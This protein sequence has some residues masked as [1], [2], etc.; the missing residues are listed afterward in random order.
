MINN[1]FTVSEDQFRQGD[2]PSI[3]EEIQKDERIIINIAES[4][5]FTSNEFPQL[6][7]EIWRKVCFHIPPRK[8]DIPYAKGGVQS[9][10]ENMHFSKQLTKIGKNEEKEWASEQLVSLKKYRCNT[11]KEAIQYAISHDLTGVNLIEFPDLEE[12]DIE[13]LFKKCPN[14][15]QLMI[16]SDKIRNL[17]IQASN[18]IRLDCKGC[19]NLQNLP[20]LPIVRVL[21]C[22]GCSNLQSLPELPNMQELNCNWCTNLHSLPELSNVQELNCSWCANLLSLPELPNVQK[23]N[24]KCLKLHSLPEL[25]NVQELNCSWCAN[26][27]SLPGLPNVQKLNCS[28]CSSLQS[29]PELPNVQK[30]DCIRCYNLLSLPE[31]PNVQELYCGWCSNLQSLPELPNVQ[32]LDFSRCSNLQN[33]PKLS[34]GARIFR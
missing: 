14:L 6:P 5:F 8:F 13:E 26:L 27:L 25:P 24:C 9:G 18:L 22:S 16:K 1:Q 29:L 11:A 28:W 3:P 17:P 32:V 34:E 30:L 23:L 20:E 7:E 19:S 33:L 4:V 10:L 31:L 2:L 12:S 21:D 15:N